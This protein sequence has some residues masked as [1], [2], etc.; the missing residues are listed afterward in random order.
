M[1]FIPQDFEQL[2]NSILKDNT[3]CITSK[4]FFNLGNKMIFIKKSKNGFYKVVATFSCGFDPIYL[5][6]HFEVLF[7]SKDL[8]QCINKFKIYVRDVVDVLPF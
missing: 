8:S 5:E 2:Y 1:D 6:S 3:S 7:A 4:Y